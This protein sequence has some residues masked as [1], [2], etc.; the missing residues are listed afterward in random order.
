MK[1]E[2][3]SKRIFTVCCINIHPLELEHFVQPG[4]K[5]DLIGIIFNDAPQEFEIFFITRTINKTELI[6]INDI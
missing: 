2:F 4:T 3:L 5:M 6:K 1:S